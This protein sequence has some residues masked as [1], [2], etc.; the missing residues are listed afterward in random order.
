MSYAL[1][2]YCSCDLG[3]CQGDGKTVGMY[4]SS[5]ARIA[6]A[7]T[8]K[9]IT[10]PTFPDS[11]GSLTGRRASYG[12]LSMNLRTIAARHHESGV[13]DTDTPAP[14]ARRFNES[15]AA[16]GSTTFTIT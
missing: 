11:R 10:A 3:L 5:A 2:A 8:R 16:S 14:S 9:A 7:P 4:R 1:T 13:T 15:A 6:Q 12:S